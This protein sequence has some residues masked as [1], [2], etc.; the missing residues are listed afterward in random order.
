MCE[1]LRA[2]MPRHSL[3]SEARNISAKLQKQLV[4]QLQNNNNNI[5]FSEVIIAKM[6]AQT[7]EREVRQGPLGWP[8]ADSR[9]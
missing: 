4:E 9:S 3:S 2:I 1:A 7:Q 6:A 8:N 5:A